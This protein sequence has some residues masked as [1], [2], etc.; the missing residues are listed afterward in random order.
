MSTKKRPIAID[1]F[2]GAGGMTL[3][4]E[5]AGFDVVTSVE[6][7]PVHCATHEYNFPFW[8]II[9][10]DVLKLTGDEI[11]SKAK[12]G[13]AEIDLVFGGPPCQGFSLMGKRAL[14]DPRN[15]LIHHFLRLVI[16]LKPKYFILENVPGLTIGKHANLLGEVIKKF[17]KAGY[18]VER[19]Y[20]LLNA[21]HFGVPQSRKRLFLVGCKSGLE[22]PDYP[23]ETT[24]PSVF[25]KRNGLDLLESSGLPFG[26]SVW[27]A[28]SDLPEVAKF[29]ELFQSDAVPATFGEC[30]DYASFLRDEQRASDDYSYRRNFDKDVLT[31]SAA[32]RHTQ[33]SI[34][35]FRATEQGDT[36]PISRFYRLDPSEI[37][38]TL[39]SGTASDRGAFTSPRPIH[40]FSARCITVREAAR[41]HSYPDWF[42]FNVTK[43]HG[44]RQIGNS[45]PPLLAKAVA[46]KLI[47]R[48]GSEF[49]TPSKRRELGN[50]DLLRMNMSQ[51]AEYYGV[52]PHVIPPRNRTK[53]AAKKKA[54]TYA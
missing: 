14:D 5:M 49:K 52:D 51:A 40:P 28:I 27:D 1:L 34:K 21:A 2:S 25:S 24:R 3:G 23:A 6:L 54:S 32:T 13:A 35:R 10:G 41:L 29:K 31:S 17:E 47:E 8:K 26:P 50:P 39:R 4:F 48:L 43:W 46:R 45:V 53:T 20:K 11:R 19:D 37:S 15:S 12:I 30:S 36:E 18:S 16:E 33:K 38:N 7:D 9:C 44:F 42:R 22:L